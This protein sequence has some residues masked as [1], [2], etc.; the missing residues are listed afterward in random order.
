MEQVAFMFFSSVSVVAFFATVETLFNSPKTNMFS[1][2]L[3]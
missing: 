1:S 2:A 3:K